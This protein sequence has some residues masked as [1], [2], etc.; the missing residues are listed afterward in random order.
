QA[1]GELEATLER[2][3]IE[4]HTIGGGSYRDPRTHRRIASLIDRHEPRAVHTHHF[5]GLA[6]GVAAATLKRV[7]RVVHTE[8]AY[9]Y[10]DERPALRRP[11]RWMSRF[12]DAF[13]LVGA[14]MRG[15]YVEGVGVAAE[16]VSVI[17]N[18]VDT[19]RYREAA[20][21]A[22]ARRAAGLP[23]G[24]LIGSAGR[25]ATVKNFPMLL[26][27]VALVRRTRPD[28][29][30][31]LA[32][33]GADRPAL[34]EQARALGYGDAV[35]FLG[36]RSDTADVLRCLDVFALTSW[37]EGLPLV[38]LEAMACGVPVVSTTVGDIPL[39]LESGKTGHL[40]PPGDA[41]ALADALAALVDDDVL[42]RRV[43]AA[44]QAFVRAEYSQHTMVERYLAA[45]GIPAP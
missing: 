21:R 35:H 2:A 15:Y 18:G 36:W 1:G 42:R 14:S 16:R 41:A 9:Q 33:D 19:A 34:E 22:A 7:P 20:D 25:F 40:V 29:R 13:V 24:T 11:L 27:A 17:V 39:I 38:I 26:D 37:T 5:A 31:V 6:S 32:G 30:L 45:Y 10:L 4:A 28:V 43:G 3:G 8:H 12:V 44:G 23:A